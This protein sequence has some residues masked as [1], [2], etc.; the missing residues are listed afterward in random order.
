MMAHVDSMVERGIKVTLV[1]P[2]FVIDG[3]GMEVPKFKTIPGVEHVT[4]KTQRTP[5]YRK[6][7]CMAMSMTNLRTLVRLIR[8]VRPDIVHG[9]QEASM[10]VLATA[11]ILCDVPLGISLHTDVAQI[12]VRDHNF[13]WIGGQVGRV[14]AWISVRFVHWGYRNWALAGATYF[15]VSQQSR[16]IL[17]NAGVGDKCIAP[18]VW[19]PMVDRQQFRVDLPE[20]RVAETRT[21]LTF[22]LPDAYLLV[23]VGRVTAEKDVQFL[24]D[25]LKRAP[26]RVVLALIGPGSLT[27]ELKKL[28]GPEHR[29]YCTGELVGRDDVALTLRSSDLHVSASTMETVGFTAMESISCGTPMLAANAQGFAL[30]LS[31]GV[32]ARL[33]TPGDTESFDRELATI[34]SLPREGNWSREALRETMGM[35]SIEAC[36]DRAFDAYSAC[37]PANVRQ[38]RKGVA[39]LF[40][41]LNWLFAFLIQ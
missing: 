21:R 3:E 1:T 41:F 16:T 2:D 6:N 36:T 40:M 9:T 29:L 4:V 12:A 27:E 20:A 18:V 39:M 32:N 28:H 5:V 35:A 37:H 22:G 13:S 14:H 23:Y 24:V 25:A 15:P 31:H 26:K 11:C 38:L 19:G 7:L 10:Q 8:R 34:M 17:K 33:F 30:Y